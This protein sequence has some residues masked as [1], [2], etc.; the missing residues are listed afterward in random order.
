ME[1]GEKDGLAG[2]KLCAAIRKEDPF[3][4]L[5]IQSSESENALY[6]S[7]YGAAFIDKNSK[8]MDVDLRR[9][10]SDNFGFGDFIFRNPDTL[11]EIARVKNLKELQNILLPYR[12][13][14]SFIISAATISA[15][16]SI[17]APCSR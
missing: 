14:H 16:G 7:K 12:Q 4:P 3:V 17:H 10:V 11:E 1:R 5:I 2:I 15:V 8:K 6:A 13:S 9:I